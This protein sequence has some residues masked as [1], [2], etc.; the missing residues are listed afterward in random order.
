MAPSD[1]DRLGQL[2]SRWEELRARGQSVTAEE[3]CR[4]CTELAP[5]LKRRMEALKAVDSVLTL[6]TQP[7]PEKRLEPKV[8]DDIRPL[9]RSR[10]IFLALANLVISGLVL[11]MGLLDPVHAPYAGTGDLLLNLGANGLSLGIL[12]ALVRGRPLTLRRLRTLEV[13]SFAL[14]SFFLAA[15][16][17]RWFHSGWLQAVPKE[18]KEREGVMLAGSGLTSPWVLLIIVYGTCIPSTGRR[19]AVIAS[20]IA[21]VP[22]LLTLVLGLQDEVLGPHLLRDVLVGNMLVWLTFAS[23]IAIF[24]SHKLTALR[25]EVLAARKL[26]QY[27]LLK[28][29]GRGGMGEVY[30][31]EHQFLKRP[32]AV[33][34]IRLDR[35]GDAGSL[36]RFEREVQA[37]ATLKH[38][39]T[40]EIYDYGHAE[41]GT[42]Y[43]VM[44]YLPGLDLETLVER[45]GPLPA[46]RA[47][48]LLRQVC[49]ALHEA[50]AVGLVHRDV[51]PGNVIVCERGGIHD[52]VKL[53]DFGL[54][55][56]VRS[57]EDTRLT[58]EGYIVGTPAYMSPEQ[59][60]GTARLDGRSDIYSLGAV[61]YFL[62]TG[63]PVF[64]RDGVLQ[65]LVAHQSAPVP[66]LRA[67]RE[68]V[69]E[70][71]AA[72]VLRCLEKSP[73]Q[74]FPD[75]AS[76]A[77]AL[78]QCDCADEWSQAEAAA[79][80]R[81]HGTAQDSTNQPPTESTAATV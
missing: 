80:W 29:L 3:L 33:K 19:C 46:A 52:V 57:P 18:G 42:F 48:H 55:T 25:R 45:G 2:L 5:E 40:V 28:R 7:T 15:A 23:A 1:D 35:A 74:R 26:G 24:G 10:L 14:G 53:L 8:E 56:S 41:D 47:V 76:L 60:A 65:V 69:P 81:D 64:P 27:R 44:E 68:E 51:K 72:V 67:L 9:L 21:L 59:A 73:A 63:R 62:L 17:Y 39:N 16:Q 66:P 13:L 77:Q 43:Y 38:W 58:R 49:A 50:H 75:A 6:R 20:S 34:L 71:L 61:A 22:L 78:Q 12:I 30:L 70:D 79:W 11:T 4:G 54:V 37:M 32:C 36:Q 31:A